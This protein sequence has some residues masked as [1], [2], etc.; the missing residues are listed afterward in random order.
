MIA[1]HI[2]MLEL[3]TYIQNVH[4]YSSLNQV[5]NHDNAKKI[6]KIKYLSEIWVAN[7]CTIYLPEL[8]ID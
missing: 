1:M 4:V 3:L 6:R 8:P 2:D 7:L 5:Y